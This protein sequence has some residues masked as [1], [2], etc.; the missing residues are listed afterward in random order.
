M[1]A[2][3]VVGP[4][5]AVAAM[6]I[7]LGGSAAGASTGTPIKVLR[8]TQL[9]AGSWQP[10]AAATSPRKETAA[11][12]RG[13]RAAPAALAFTVTATV[14]QRVKVFWSVSC[15]GQAYNEMFNLQGSFKFQVPF[16]AYPPILA[17]ATKCV[18]IVRATPTR[19]GKARAVVFGY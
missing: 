4:V 9:T 18:A 1:A 7:A 10:L 6:V 17:N 2:L 3:R 19:G 12:V 14:P 16:S 5:S 13:F 15:D 8:G 11:F